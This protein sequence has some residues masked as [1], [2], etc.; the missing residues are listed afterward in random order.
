MIYTVKRP[1]LHYSIH[2]VEAADPEEA[3]KLV[4]DGDG[5]DEVGM[6]YS[7]TFDR[8]AGWEFVG[9]FWKVSDGSGLVEE[10]DDEDARKEKF[11]QELRRHIIT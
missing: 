9:D 4:L 5:E 3:I 2:E 1:E 8:D 6:E 7:H 10:V 11:F